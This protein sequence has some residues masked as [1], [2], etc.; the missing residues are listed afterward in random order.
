M[1]ICHCQTQICEGG[2]KKKR[3]RKKNQKKKSDESIRHRVLRT[4]CLKKPCSKDTSNAIAL[5]LY[6]NL[7]H[8]IIHFSLQKGNLLAG[9]AITLS[10]MTGTPGNQC[11]IANVVIFGIIASAVQS[12]DRVH[13][14]VCITV[15]QKCYYLIS[16]NEPFCECH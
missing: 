4:G 10:A 12:S 16:K 8:L 5:P 14:K 3:R 13:N 2:I 6:P 11:L 7:L 9:S 1:K 15:F